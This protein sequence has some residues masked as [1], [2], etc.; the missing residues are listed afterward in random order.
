MNKN[1]AKAKRIQYRQWL[2]AN[3]HIAVSKLDSIE[4]EEKQGRNDPC[5]C[6]SGKKFKRCCL[7]P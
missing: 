3:P 5:V 6:G 1:I 4:K 7:K 2:A